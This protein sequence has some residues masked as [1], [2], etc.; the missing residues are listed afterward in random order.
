MNLRGLHHDPKVWGS[1]ADVFR[2]ERFLNGGWENLPP[3]S[4]KAFGDGARACIGRTFAEQEMIMV[5]ALI[6]QKFQVELADPSYQLRMCLPT[7]MVEL[8]MK[9]IADLTTDVSV[10]ITQKPKDLRIKVRRRP[11]RT[12]ASLSGIGGGD[13][14]PKQKA[15][16]EKKSTGDASAPGRDSKP[17]T[18]L[19]GSNAGTCK[20]YA[21]DLETNAS[22]YGFKATVASL[23]SVTERIP[24][25]QPVVIIEPSYEGK[26]ADNAKKFTAWLEGSADSKS[27]EGVQYAIFG[28]GNSEWVHTYHRVPK[29]TDE[30]LE[31]MGAKRFTETGLV[32]V[33]EDIM[34]PWESWAEQ[35]WDDLRK[36]SGTTVEVLGG[37]LQADIT[38]PK[39]ATYLGGTDI[40]YGEVKINKVLG[41]GEVG[42]SKKHMEIELPM[43]TSYRSGDYMV[44]LPI[45]SIATVRRVMKRF[46]LAP[47]DN[48]AITGTNKTYIA[49]D[50][51]VSI[52]DLLMTRVELSTPISPKQLQILAEVA[53]ENTRAKLISL[54]TDEV[55]KK[56]VIP[57][58][59]S[60]LDVLED[61]PDC[62]LPFATYLD[63]LKPLSPRQYSISSSPLANIEFVQTPQ[64]VGQRLTASLTYDVHDEA[65]WS[66][67]N[68][69]FHGVAS[70]YLAR[71]EPGEKIRCFT[72]PTNINFHL[73]LDPTVPII[74]ICAGSGFAP[75]RGFIQERATI[76]AAR[77]A[78]IGPA[79]LYFGCR[80]HEKDFLYANELKQ[81]EADGVVSVRGCFS[82][83]APE[84]QKAQ[85][86]PDRMWDERKELAQLFGEGGAKVFICGSAGKLAKSTAEMCMKI[87][88]DTFPEKTEEEALEWLEKVKED[89]FVSDVFE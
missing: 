22:R 8:S 78:A 63:S 53:P 33:K 68:R 27:L 20:S 25:D 48:I 21:E 85:R 39:F 41:G 24:K 30:L 71:Q 19:Y 82:K 65:A 54:A 6:L 16:D 77:N 83:V 60:I 57:K 73:P 86:V 62:Q 89:R 10:T 51:P 13:A 55:Y 50:H 76:K 18:V 9:S 4:W 49:T 64:G 79:V 80:H 66:G 23:D 40:G 45:N 69:R 72:R 12:M 31:K 2:P 70:T 87:Y 43:G 84:G 81:W 32:N 1:D 47:D 36:S 11:G 29:L 7:P 35:M 88:R 52:F 3:N 17:I 44:I 67:E 58:R 37:Q 26:P 14:A 38:P 28:V 59:Y 15:A 42:L 46:D 74:M 56:E 5:V 34:G 75:M 61:F